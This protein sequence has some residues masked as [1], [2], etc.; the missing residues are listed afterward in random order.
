MLHHWGQFYVDG[1]VMEGN[2]DV[3]AD[4]WTKGI[5]AQISSSGNDNTFTSVTKDTMRLDAPLQFYATTTHTAQVAYEK[6]CNMPGLVTLA[7]STT[8]LWWPMCGK[9]KPHLPVA[10]T[11]LE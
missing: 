3:T 8:L 1:N 6:C 10:P 11:C 2:A 5:Y 7:M 9:T 4:N